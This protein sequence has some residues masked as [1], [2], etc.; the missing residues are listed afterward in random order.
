MKP[1]DV[2][3]LNDPYNG[4]THLPDVTVITPS[5]SNARTEFDGASAQNRTRPSFYVGSRGHHADI[6]GIT[7]GSMP[8]FSQ[9]IEEEGVLIDNVKLVEDGR[10]LRSRDARSLLGARALS[11]AQSRPEHRRPARAG[12]RQREG[13]A[14]VEAHGR[15]TSAWTSCAPT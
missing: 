15:R 1:G 10:M 11:G 12:R 3:V 13:R 9:T 6:G 8:P 2:Y 7:P 4:G 5:S 14:G